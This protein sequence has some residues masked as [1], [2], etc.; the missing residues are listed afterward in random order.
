M[1]KGGRPRCHRPGSA[2]GGSAW[3]G[4]KALAGV[5]R[6]LAD[7]LDV[8]GYFHWSALDTFEWMDGY[9]PRFGLIA[10]DR[11]K[12]RRI[13][14]SAYYLGQMARTGLATPVS[15]QP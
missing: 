9:A 4:G 5:R 7:G 13:K 15:H 8:R 10:I 11:D 14:G 6:C 3:G 2:W 1:R 12:S